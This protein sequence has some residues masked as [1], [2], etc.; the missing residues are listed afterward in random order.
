MCFDIPAVTSCAH[1]KNS[2]EY[3]ISEAHIVEV[4]LITI[5]YDKQRIAVF[6]S[7][8]LHWYKYIRAIPFE[9][10]KETYRGVAFLI[11]I[12]PP[13]VSM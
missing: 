8:T 9:N 7:S 6:A 2:Y 12:Y 10:L 1:T 11:Q 4:M 13:V 3:L 5:Y